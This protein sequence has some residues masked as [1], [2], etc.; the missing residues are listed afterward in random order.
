MLKINWQA[1]VEKRK[2][3]IVSDTQE[4]LRIN[5]ILD[6]S[7]ITVSQPFGAGI[8]Q[9]LE[10]ILTKGE[11]FSFFVK[12]VDGYAGVI[13]YGQ[14]EESVGVLCHIDVVPTGEGWTTSPFSAA[15]RNNRIYARGAIDNKGPTIAAFWALAI[16]KELKLPIHKR[17]RMILGT[18]EE[19]N[20]RCVDHYFKHEEM[21]TIGFA[22][23]ADFP[24]IHAEKGITDV[25]LVW[26]ARDDK[27]NQ[28]IKVL[29]FKAGDRFNMVPD[30]AEVVITGDEKLL[31]EM[32][33][34]FTHFL[35]GQNHK[36]TTRLNGNSLQIVYE[37]ISAHGST[38]EK[39]VNAGLFLTQF[40]ATYSFQSTANHFFQFVEKYSDFT[41]EALGIAVQDDASG[42]LS[43]NIGKLTFSEN[44]EAEVGLN[45][46]YPVTASGEECLTTLK[47]VAGSNHAQMLVH[48]HMKPNYVEKDHPLIQTLQD[49]YE[50]QTGEEPTLL[51]IGGGTY[52]RSLKTGVAFGPMFP[53]R[54]D[55]AHKKDECIDIDDLLRMTALYAEAMYEL[56]K[57]ASQ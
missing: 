40:L 26:N 28:K 15:I 53:G 3:E 46:R 32:K 6:D 44:G 7:T 39:G 51:A 36:G 10:H 43:M 5:S 52:A 35:V 20:W 57:E 11:K 9:A 14:G 30:Q 22:P 24:I 50:R 25:S 8:A 56:A 37:G 21:P 12:N 48:D 18:D 33:D 55:V 17:I 38:P 45:I 42:K 47:E 19:S 41:G 1:E 31:K 34:Q 23:D 2:E 13:E 16:V 27:D 29:Q 54:E 4:F 49:V